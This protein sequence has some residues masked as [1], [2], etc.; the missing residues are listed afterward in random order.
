V[1]PDWTARWRPLLLIIEDDPSARLALATILASLRANILIAEDGLAGLKLA[2]ARQP[3]VILLDLRIPGL[4]G[5]EVLGRLRAVGVLARVIVVSGFLDE[6]DTV[7]ERLADLGVMAC[8]AKPFRFDDLLRAVQ[9]ALGDDAPLGSAWAADLE[10]SPAARCVVLMLRALQTPRDVKTCEGL[11]RCGAISLSTF[12]TLCREAELSP[13][14]VRDF[15]RVLV[16]LVWARR[17]ECGME[18]LLRIG[19]SRSWNGLSARAGLAD[20]SGTATVRDFL[21]RQ[22]FI[23]QTSQVFRL[24]RR[25]LL[26]DPMPRWP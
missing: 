5:E 20:Q 17:L 8:L 7:R 6:N 14:N 22:T 3:H 19:D 1:L 24:L 16:A 11:A 23:L 25:A 26:G 4:P 18:V 9:N 2:T 12:K 10:D 21:E 13:A 15:V